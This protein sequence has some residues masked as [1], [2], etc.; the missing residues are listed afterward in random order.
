L[1]AGLPAHDR[2]QGVVRGDLVIDEA[3]AAAR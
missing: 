3:I 2:E 1:K